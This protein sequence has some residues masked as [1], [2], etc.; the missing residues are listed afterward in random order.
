M[1]GT[2][3]LKYLGSAQRGGGERSVGAQVNP[4]QTEISADMGHYFGRAPLYENK[5][6]NNKNRAPLTVGAHRL[7]IWRGYFL[8]GASLALILGHQ[9]ALGAR[10]PS[11]KVCV[12]P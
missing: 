1:R 6:R 8:H 9:L 10:S 11:P 7:L 3:S 2:E 12:G 4:S 5:I